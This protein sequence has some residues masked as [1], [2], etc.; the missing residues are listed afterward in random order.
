MCERHLPVEI[1]ALN[2]ID[3]DILWFVIDSEKEVMQNIYS[4]LSSEIGKKRMTMPKI[5]PFAWVIVFIAS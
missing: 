1:N 4:Q 2:I 5:E 3:T